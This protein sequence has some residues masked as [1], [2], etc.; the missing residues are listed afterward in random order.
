MK[1]G[2][3]EKLP[4]SQRRDDI[5]KLLREHQVV[6]IAGETG[7]GKTTQLPKIC[8][9]LGLAENGLIAHTQPRRIAARS[10]AERIAHETQVALGDEVGYQVRFKDVSS[11]KTC[12][13]LMTDGVLLAEIQ[14][15]RLLR[16]YQTIIIDEAHERSLNIDFL[17]GLLKP[18]CHKRPDLKLIITSATIDLQRFADHFSVDGKPAPILEV[19]GRTYPVDT[20]YKPLEEKQSEIP[21]AIATTVK[22]IIR[23]E[24]KGRFQ[25]S[26]DILVFCAGERDIHEARDALNKLN[27]KIEILPLYSRLSVKEQNRVFQPTQRRKVVLATNVAET[28]ITVPG[29]AYVIDPGLARVSRYSFRSKIQRLPIESISQASANQRKGRCGRVANG[30]C[31]RLYSEENFELRPEFTEAEILRSNLAAVLLKMKRLGIKNPENFDFIDKPDARLLNDGRKLLIEL[32]AIESESRKDGKQKALRL[33]TIGRQMSDLPIDPRFAR[34]LV[35]ANQCNCLLDAIVL[36]SALSIQDPR[37]RASD[38]SQAGQEFHR[39]LNH[40]HSD[41]FTFLILWQTLKNQ[42]EQLSNS[43]FREYCLDSYLSIARV[44]EWRELVGQIQ[45]HCRQL[46]WNINQWVDITEEHQEPKSSSNSHSPRYAQLHR[47]LLS[48]FLSNVLNRDI[49]GELSGLRNKN[50]H[51]FPTSAI[52]KKKPR[53]ILV[54]EFLETNRVYGINAAAIAPEWIIDSAK[55]QLKYRYSTPRYD[56]KS[57]LIKANRSTLYHGLVLRDRELINYTAIAPEECLDIFIQEA[58]V[59]GKYQPIGKRAEFV[60]HNRRQIKQVESLEAKTRRRNILISEEQLFDFYKS[61]LPNHVNSRRKLEQWLEQG[62]QDALKMSQ[63]DLVNGEFASNE[64]SNFPNSLAVAG[65]KIKIK[66]QFNPGNVGDGVTTLV[67]VSVLAHFPESIGEW[68]VPGLL[69]EKCV[70]MIKTLPKPIRRNFA[71]AGDYVSKVLP[72]L[73][74]YNKEQDTLT[75]ALADALFRSRGVKVSP[76]DFDIGKLEALYRMNYQVI[77]GEGRTL[78]HGQD[79]DQLKDDYSSLVKEAIMSSAGSDR[80][81]F[82]K[83]DIQDWSFGDIPDSVQ[84]KHAGMMVTAY[85]CLKVH[86]SDRIDLVLSDNEETAQYYSHHGT[87]ALAKKVLTKT[88]QK[89]SLKYLRRE[90]FKPSSNHNNKKSS[91]GLSQLAAQLKS[92]PL[93]IADKDSWCEAII[94]HALNQVCFEGKACRVKAKLEFDQGIGR[95]KSW[96]QKAT[97]T[98]ELMVKAFKQRDSLLNSMSKTPA[99]NIAKDELYEDIKS[100][101]YRWLTPDMLTYS[102]TSDVRQL[103]R[104]LKMCEMRLSRGPIAATDAQEQLKYWQDRLNTHIRANTPNDYSEAFYKLTSPWSHQFQVFL[105]EWRVSIYAQQLKTM[106]PVSDKRAAALWKQHNSTEG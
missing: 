94:D 25:T 72:Q 42:K 92:V 53:W 45:R 37:E 3:P 31:F 105:D 98:E 57:G 101:L 39:S 50:V 96:V 75:S 6:I 64:L 87:I 59:S 77:D 10:V 22:E 33:T 90:L 11:K 56:I 51:L 65:K 16:K 21:Q 15:D 104:Y 54:A 73:N 1:L 29:I 24:A 84:Y 76:N 58:L 79:L 70:A 61:K 86:Q 78:G 93:T 20:V 46:K 83:S 17:L 71:P 80:N 18:I 55:G 91:P 88:S 89:Q 19:S 40:A 30:V 41:F 5:A 49:N 63:A 2:Y 47:V 7:S 26:G 81:K 44:F 95:A 34:I 8:I 66:Y 103:A 23:D 74:Q 62:N 38:S 69:A 14:H 82:E 100:D 35:E 97:E 48:G 99:P 60:R 85:A 52:A 67:P 12:L 27:L 102:S 106:F 28:S 36:I 43:K 68:L 32:G 13:K 4:I 9:E